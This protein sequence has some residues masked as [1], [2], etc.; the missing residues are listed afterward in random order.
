MT[1]DTTHEHIEPVS[2]KTITTV[3]VV[4]L[5]L[6]AALVAVSRVSPFWAVAAMLT[7]TPLK[8]ALVFY[9]FMHLKYEGPLIKGMVAI[10]LTVLVIFIG[11]MF[12]DVAFR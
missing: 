3:W 5:A 6:T 2:H 7:L 1:M 4:L 12:L 11:M 9:Y 8:A 10:A